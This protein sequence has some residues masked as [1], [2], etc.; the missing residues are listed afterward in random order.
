MLTPGGFGSLRDPFGSAAVENVLGQ[1][2]VPPK[3]GPGD[4]DRPAP[5]AG[6][7]VAQWARRTAERL[8]AAVLTGRV[9]F[10]QWPDWGVDEE[11]PERRRVYWNM[12]AEPM[13][14]T[15]LLL[16]VDAVASLDV[17]VHPADPDDPTESELADF[18]RHNFDR[19]A[20]G[21]HNA[22][23]AVLLPGKVCG[24]SV[25]E[26]LWDPETRGRWA[27]RWCWREWR[28]KDLRAL[29]PIVDEFDRVVGVHGPSASGGFR[30]YDPV[31]FLIFT[32]LKFFENPLGRSALRAAYRAWWVKD[33]VWQLRGIHLEKYTSP[34][35]LATYQPGMEADQ[36]QALEAALQNCQA[37]TWLTVPAGVAVDAVTMA[38]KDTSDFKDAIDD[39]N[40]EMLIAIQGSHLPVL[41]G[42]TANVAG[43]T[44]EQR[45]S[46][47][48]LQWGLAAD[49]GVAY[50]KAAAELARVNGYTCPPPRVTVGSVNDQTL[51]N[52]LEIDQ[53]LKALGFKLSR[54]AIARAYNRQ[55]ATEPD[56]VLGETGPAGGGGVDPGG[57]NGPPGGQGAPGIDPDAPNGPPAL[58][59]ARGYSEPRGGEFKTGGGRVGGK[60]GSKAPGRREKAKELIRHGLLVGTHAVGRTGAALGAAEHAVTRFVSRNVD[61]LPP[62]AR[63][64][65][66]RAWRL[67]FAVF[68]AGQGAAH[69]VARRAGLSPEK[70]DRLAHALAVADFVAFKVAKVAALGHVPGG[71]AAL[72]V[73]GSIPVASA[74]YLALSAAR[75]PVEVFRAARDAVRKVAG[76][77]RRVEPAAAFAETN[78]AAPLL[79][80]R[81]ARLS[82]EALERYLALVYA[83]LDH[84]GG[85]LAA[86]VRLADRAVGGDEATGAGPSHSA[87]PDDPAGRR[88]DFHDR[89][90]GGA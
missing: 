31:D 70:A 80:R 4:T 76:S 38:T 87:E 58:P 47:E 1:A 11:T 24:W 23:R 85:D 33:A 3:F 78:P 36:R 84:T 6:A 41:E 14:L 56:D 50:T 89:R 52:S 39:A 28:S 69:E 32:H 54:K 62:K 67:T 29:W 2:L 46:A 71:H 51:K 16:Q 86:A 26:K 65:A 55:E 82:G 30:V 72:A 9:R 59:A 48:T 74:G 77:V 45:G 13:I 22:A 66:I 64:A 88:R 12:L 40:K 83:A 21:T 73:A 42:A 37:S 15:P 90:K 18:T 27:G 25:T 19:L 7:D 35:L 57:G 79:A 17:Q 61:R 10:A 68:S 20:D 43:N 44:Q 34:F 81:L 63:N 75:H 60:G 53:G 49:L 8:R 5:P